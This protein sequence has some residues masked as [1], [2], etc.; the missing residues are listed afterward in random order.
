M[1][2]TLMNNSCLTLLSMNWCQLEEDGAFYICQGLAKNK[3][4][5][6]LKLSNNN[7]GDAGI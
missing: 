7:F 1:R 5:S 6:T 3:K 4:L 2:E